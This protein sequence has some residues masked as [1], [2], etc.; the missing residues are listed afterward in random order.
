MAS[1]PRSRRFGLAEG[2]CGGEESS[3]ADTGGGTG[4]AASMLG[5]V[6]GTRLADKGA[7]ASGA[8]DDAGAEG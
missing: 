5:C 3:K 1:S 4:A 7:R 6:S 2:G 8:W